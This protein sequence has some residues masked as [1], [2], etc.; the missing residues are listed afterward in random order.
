[1]LL[2]PSANFYQNDLFL[3]KTFQEHYEIKIK[4]N[5]RNVHPDLGQNC[6]LRQKLQLQGKDEKSAQAIFKKC[7]RFL[8]CSWNHEY[9]R[10]LENY[11]LF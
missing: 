11:S 5:V 2:L 1:M 8:E 9:F 10:S 4:T 7:I 6:L 3:K